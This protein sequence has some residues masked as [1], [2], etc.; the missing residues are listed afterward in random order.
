VSHALSWRYV[1]NAEPEFTSADMDE[2]IIDAVELDVFYR[3][4]LML[5]GCH[6]CAYRTRCFHAALT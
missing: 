6:L 4:P 3:N 2:G 1:V 5:Y